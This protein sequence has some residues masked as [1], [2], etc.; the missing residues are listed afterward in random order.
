MPDVAKPEVTKE[1]KKAASQKTVVCI[2]DDRDF[3]DLI[4]LMLN[5]ANLKVITALGGQA[6]LEAIRQN[7]PDL[8]LLDL[9]MPDMHGWEVYMK[10]RADEQSSNIPVIVVTALATQYDRSFGLRV[11]KVAD[12][13]TKPFMASHLR[14]RI[15][16]VLHN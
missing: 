1:D 4:R 16:A 5:D 6:G 9:M 8:V 15:Q 3:L 14:E 7:H 12:Y 10:M 2:E 11:A 13:I